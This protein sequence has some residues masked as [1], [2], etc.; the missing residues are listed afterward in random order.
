M[1]KLLIASGVLLLAVVAGFV[2][3]RVRL[4]PLLRARVVPALAEHYR[5]EV[6]LR[7]L[8]IRPYPFAAVGRGLALAH[9]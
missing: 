5:G 7:E 1:R 3:A 4:R 8:D 2:Y 9:R 6:D